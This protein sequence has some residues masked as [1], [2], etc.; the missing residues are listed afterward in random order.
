M[1][2]SIESASYIAA[3]TFRG[4]GPLTYGETTF[5]QVLRGMLKQIR[6]LVA[7]GGLSL[8]PMLAVAR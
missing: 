3:E 5:E 2:G 7:L 8:R 4:M 1:T 6:K